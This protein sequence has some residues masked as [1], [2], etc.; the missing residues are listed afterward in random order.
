[1]P[2]LDL[3]SVMKA[4]A[5]SLLMA[6]C[7]S[8]PMKMT[9][10]KEGNWHARALIRDKDHSRTFIVNLDFNAI[11]NQSLRVDVSSTLGQ[12]VASLVVNGKDV[13]YFTTDNKRFYVGT[14]RPE[15][16]RPI[17]AIPLDPRW[18][19][20]VLF[21]EAPKTAGWTCQNDAQGFVSE[22]RYPATNLK[23]AWSNRKGESKSVEITHPRAEIQL[24]VR[25]FTA[26]VEKMDHLFDLQMPEGYQKLRLR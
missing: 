6:G 17:L 10:V 3:K 4:F 18:L 26:K 23:I 11:R 8:A 16:L 20:N 5:F 2:R 21:D 1:M 24:N 14:A 15:V 19:Q 9:D 25:S 12:Q 7:T 22:C 13:R